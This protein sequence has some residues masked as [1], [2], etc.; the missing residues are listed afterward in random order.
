MTSEYIR[1][2]PF[3][4][5]KDDYAWMEAMRGPRWK[6]VLDAEKEYS[7][8]Y[9]HQTAVQKRIPNYRAHYDKAAEKDVPIRFTAGNGRV[10]IMM[11]S[12]F[13]YQ[14][15]FVHSTRWYMCRD[16]AVSLNGDVWNTHDIG[17]GSE[18]FQLSYF[19]Y[20]A[21]KPAW[22]ITNVGPDVA[23]KDGICYYL[24][25]SN[26][27]WYNRLYAC[28][29]ASGKQVTLLYENTNPQIN[30]ALMKQANKRLL[31]SLEDSQ[32][33]TYYE[34]QRKKLK[35]VSS[36]YTITGSTLN[37]NP[38]E[39]A[40]TNFI[41]TKKHGTKT[42]WKC[43]SSG[44]CTKRLL[45]ISVGEILPNPWALWYGSPFIDI[46]VLQPDKT[47]AYYIYDGE[48]LQLLYPPM[49][50]GLAC[51]KYSAKSQDG[52]TVHYNVCYKDN[53]TPTK[54]LVIG[55]GA[56]G[57]PTGVGNVYLR[58]A[59]LL[60]NNWAIVTT[61]LR[62]GGDYNEAWA[63]AGRLGGRAKTIDDFIACIRDARTRFHISAQRTV[64]HGR[65]AGGL[66]VA[67]TMQR[68][69]NG[70]LMG[71]I[72]TEVPY[73]DELRTTSNSDLPLTQ[74]EY[75][76]FGNPTRSVQEFLDIGLLSPVN[77]ATELD[78]SAIFVLDRT[79]EHDSQVFAYE[80]VK[81]IQ[82]LR[83]GQKKN[84]LPKLLVFEEDQGHFTPPDQ[85]V[86]QHSLDAALL[87]A[88]VSG[89]LRKTR[90]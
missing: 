87:D 21:G 2:T 73:V 15:R 27:L 81:W 36:P 48:N 49:P 9:I 26:K 4:S 71:G 3:A 19:P 55:Y 84:S 67:G 78:T 83:H 62:G 44:Q 64:I 69:P 59:P 72:Y 22:N 89:E 11:L 5:W 18:K 7:N 70:D 35:H 54:L 24:G 30:I 74:L 23:E 85:A 47:Q 6:K 45:S 76:E 57:M 43:N 25:V 41:I 31:V 88:L 33:F 80:S 56:Y 52:T 77:S 61:F 79:A 86:Q 37:T 50:N 75:N 60:E 29:A 14:W 32:D 39:T 65:S 53:K 66:L 1:N 8:K 51:Q 10:E 38:I 90:A 16:I 17:N 40:G 13:F 46:W 68:Y 82:R 42:L 58:W 34:I 20:D 12:R 63:K 28:N